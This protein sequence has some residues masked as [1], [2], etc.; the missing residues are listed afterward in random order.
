MIYRIGL[1][2]LSE[3]SLKLRYRYL[4]MSGFTA[5]VSAFVFWD[6]F[7]SMEVRTVVTVEQFANRIFGIVGL[8]ALGYFIINGVSVLGHNLLLPKLR[9]IQR[10]TPPPRDGVEE[11]FRQ[12]FNTHRLPDNEG[13]AILPAV[14]FVG[15]FVLH[16]GIISAVVEGVFQAGTATLPFVVGYFAVFLTSILVWV[17]ALRVSLR[18]N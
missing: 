8:Q 5:S 2:T 1:K 14:H 17:H 15:V 12:V 7:V 9:Q 4:F 10:D 16:A 18:G 13:T 11:L 6:T 3:S